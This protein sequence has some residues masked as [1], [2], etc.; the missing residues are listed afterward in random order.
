MTSKTMMTTAHVKLESENDH[1]PIITDEVASVLT[2]LIQ[3][4]GIKVVLEIGTA[5]SYSAH[6]M[7]DAGA[8]IYTA[9][10]QLTRLKKAQSFLEHSMHKSR[11]H[12]IP[13]DI[14]AYDFKN[15]TFDLIFLDGAKSQYQQIFE[16]VSPYLNP[17]GLIVC[18]NMYFHD[19]K[20]EDAGRQAKKLLTKLDAF[21][22]FLSN[23]DLFETEMISIGDG[24]SVSWKKEDI[25]A[26]I[27]KAY[28][29]T[30]ASKY[31]T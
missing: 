20:K 21:K 12:L 7:A 15:Q 4:K 17:H 25:D 31:H 16:F 1:I 23:H 8:T 10:R 19:Y 28:I 29:K 18:D 30:F 13:H 26:K 9:E 14:K 24:L 27:T 22:A 6:V 3:T 11:I 5:Y 2:A